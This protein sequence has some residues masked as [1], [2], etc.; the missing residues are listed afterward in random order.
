VQKDQSVSQMAEEVLMSQAKALAQRSGHSLEDGRQAVSDTEA[1]RQPLDAFLL[2]V[3]EVSHA[4]PSPL[5][6][7]HP[8]PP[9]PRL[10]GRLSLSP[11]RFRGI[12]RAGVLRDLGLYNA[13]GRAAA[14]MSSSAAF[15]LRPLR[16]AR[17]LGWC[18]YDYPRWDAHTT[19]SMP[20]IP[21][22]SAHR[23]L[24]WGW[25]SHTGLQP[26]ALPHPN[27]LRTL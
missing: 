22:C 21:L 26:F 17:D 13:L 12:G 8:T 19:E 10:S 9:R 27:R 15:A 16:I 24:S 5:P 25:S 20:T 1:G 6:L 23:L 18:E 3:A 7:E 4:S 14:P 11:G 2:C